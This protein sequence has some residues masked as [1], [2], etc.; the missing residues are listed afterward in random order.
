M[1][2]PANPVVQAPSPKA[3]ESFPKENL[4][5]IAQS[6][7]E[8]LEKP[9]EAPKPPP[10]AK[11]AEPVRKIVEPKVLE[12]DGVNFTKEE[13]LTSVDDKLEKGSR[14]APHATG[15]SQAP[16]VRFDKDR[17]PIPPKEFSRAF[18]QRVKGQG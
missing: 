6:F 4:T 12:I 13:K 1:D 8:A 7:V 10:V 15:P 3:A 18:I 5:P 9:K 17:V 16:E 2:I 11:P 14:G